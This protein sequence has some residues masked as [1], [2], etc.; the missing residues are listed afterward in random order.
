MFPPRLPFLLCFLFVAM[1]SALVT[2]IPDFPSTTSP[3]SPSSFAAMSRRNILQNL[4]LASATLLLPNAVHA[5]EPS[6]PRRMVAIQLQ[7]GDSLGLQIADTTVRGKPVAFIQKVVVNNLKNRKLQEGMIL[8]G[9]DSSLQ[10]IQ[11]IQN[12]PYPIDLEFVNLAAGGDAFDDLGNSMVT[13]RDA[14]SLAQQTENSSS[15]A[16]V[17]KPSYSITSLSKPSGMCAIQSRR[18]DVLEFLYDAF[19]VDADDTKKLYDSSDFRG[20]GRPYQSVLGSGDMIPGV[21]QGLYDMCPGEVRQLRIPPILAYGKRARDSFRIPPSYQA[22]EWKV[23]LVSIDSTIRQD[24]NNVSRDD[25]E[26]RA[27]Y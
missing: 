4:C 16:A 3:A 18:G 24:N 13:P 17:A 21:D 5:A 2:R 6:D 15:G 9:Y 25:R 20:T 7:K 12:G 27:L 19:Y 23:E 10:I 26:S 11:R 1:S 22:L 14:L 8:N